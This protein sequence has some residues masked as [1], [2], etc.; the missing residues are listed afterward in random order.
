MSEGCLG[1]EGRSLYL[2]NFF[3]LSTPFGELMSTKQLYLL[4]TLSVPS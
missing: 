3:A 4:A 1:T 2:Y